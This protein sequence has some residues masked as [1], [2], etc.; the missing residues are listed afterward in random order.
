[1]RLLIFVCLVFLAKIQV[2]A[3]NFAPYLTEEDFAL[4]R[5]LDQKALAEE[6]AKSNR[7]AN[8][9]E[10]DQKSDHLHQRGVSI[11]S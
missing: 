11:I 9:S 6:Y 3:T 1:M 4:G 5:I 2:E 10:P 8:I 7:T